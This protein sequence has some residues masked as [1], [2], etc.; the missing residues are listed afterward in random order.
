MPRIA[1]TVRRVGRRDRAE[2]G[3]RLPAL[4]DLHVAVDQYVAERPDEG[5]QIV[6][7]GSEPSAALNAVSAASYVDCP[8]RTI[9]KPVSPSREPV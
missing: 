2:A 4:P 7:R 9:P 6:R 5:R 1:P 8:S 3:E